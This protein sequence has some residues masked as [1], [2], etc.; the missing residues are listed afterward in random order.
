MLNNTFFIEKSTKQECSRVLILANKI[1]L[2][3]Q[4]IEK[5]QNAGVSENEIFCNN[6]IFELK[7][8]LKLGLT[9]VIIEDHLYNYFTYNL[10]N[11]YLENKAISVIIYHSDDELKTIR[12]I[13][14][15]RLI[16]INKATSAVLLD[17]LL[18]EGIAKK[19]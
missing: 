5:C 2:Q 3:A 12:L 7:N 19:F 17:K 1:D 11:K 4:L 8:Y 16:H 9:H 10:L 6:S 14:D 13:T 15:E 18:Y